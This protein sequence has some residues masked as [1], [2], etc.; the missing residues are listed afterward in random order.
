MGTNKCEQNAQ[1]VDTLTKEKSLV[2]E[3]LKE[4]QHELQNKTAAYSELDS[5]LS[6]KETRISDM[7]TVIS[8]TETK[9]NEMKEAIEAAKGK[10][11]DLLSTIEENKKM[12]TSIE[13]EKS[14]HIET[15]QNLL[16]ISA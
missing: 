8:A 10:E 7:Q 16:K 12:I 6:G 13:E 14:Y 1:L 4:T 11:R 2:E 5:Q 3:K 15:S 9:V